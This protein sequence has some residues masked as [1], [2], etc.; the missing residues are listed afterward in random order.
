MQASPEFGLHRSQ[1]R[2][3]PRAHRLAQHREPTFSRLRAAVR[4]AQKV[5]GF[6]FPVPAGAPILV[7]EATKFDE[8]RLVGMQRQSKSRETR[9]QF[10]EEACGFRPMLESRDEIVRETHDHD[11]AV[12][13]RRSPSLDPQVEDIVQIEIGE[14]RTPYSL[15]AK[16]NFQF[17]RVIVGWRAQTV[18]DLRRK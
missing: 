14:Q 3:P 11:V 5:E 2:L 13:L 16:G 4:E 10:G 9:A 6:R 1:L 17:E 7:S 18:L 12:R 8:P 15:Y